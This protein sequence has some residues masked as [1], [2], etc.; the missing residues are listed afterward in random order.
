MLLKEPGTVLCG[1]ML[2]AYTV[3]RETL[4]I[5]GIS[6]F[7]TIWKNSLWIKMGESLSLSFNCNHPGYQWAEYLLWSLGIGLLNTILLTSAMIHCKFG[8]Q[9][10]RDL[11]RGVNCGFLNNW[12]YSIS[13]WYSILIMFLVWKVLWEEIDTYKDTNIFLKENREGLYKGGIII[14][15]CKWA[16]CYLCH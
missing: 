15:S 10:Y 14:M 6:L 3:Q 16:N 8:Q 13:I 12:N 1:K 4:L 7:L 5:C 11:G 9:S 2:V